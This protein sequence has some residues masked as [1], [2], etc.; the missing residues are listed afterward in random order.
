MINFIAISFLLGHFF[1][2]WAFWL[3]FT[4]HLSVWLIALAASK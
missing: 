4:A 2:A 1:G 3:Y